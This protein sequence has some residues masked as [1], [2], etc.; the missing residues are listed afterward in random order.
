MSAPPN[1]DDGD[2]PGRPSKL[3]PALTAAV[4]ELL[5]RGNYRSDVARAAGIGF[6]T[7]RRWMRTGRQYPD[8]IYG[9]FRQAVESAESTFKTRAVGTV[10]SA[11]EDDP[12]LLLEYLARRYPQQ[13]GAYRGELGELKRRIKQMEKLVEGVG[14][15]AP[16]PEAP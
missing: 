16:D 2:R 3:T 15:K 9:R 5:L 8:G 12:R 10:T 7:F 6:T 11:G 14:G 4:V 1:P 13:F